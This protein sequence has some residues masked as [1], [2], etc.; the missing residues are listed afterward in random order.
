MLMY[1]N[2]V[3]EGGETAFPVAGN[4]TLD[5]A[6]RALDSKIVIYYKICCL[7]DSLAAVILFVF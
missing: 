1:L 6:V 5:S 2:E 3:E 4:A 7:I